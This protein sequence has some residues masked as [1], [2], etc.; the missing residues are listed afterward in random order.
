MICMFKIQA[1]L[2][3]YLGG[4]TKEYNQKAICV[5]VWCVHVCVLFPCV[6]AVRGSEYEIGFSHFTAARIGISFHTPSSKHAKY[7]VLTWFANSTKASTATSGASA[8]HNNRLVAD[9][10]PLWV[11]QEHS[12]AQQS[13]TSRGPGVIHWLTSFGFQYYSSC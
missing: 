9:A 8:W 1:G 4:D 2:L 5:C 13:S 12:W 7:S 11:T 6:C 3:L 10:K